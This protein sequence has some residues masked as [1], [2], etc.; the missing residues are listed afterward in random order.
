MSRAHFAR[1]IAAR[2]S[3]GY[4]LCGLEW[5]PFLFVL[6]PPLGTSKVADD[7]QT[8]LTKTQPPQNVGILLLIVVALPNQPFFKIESCVWANK[9]TIITE[10]NVVFLILFLNFMLIIILFSIDYFKK[11][12]VIKREK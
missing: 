12:F 7:L 6:R 9:K 1:R 11:F 8:P 10:R 3:R 5:P 2:Q 4:L